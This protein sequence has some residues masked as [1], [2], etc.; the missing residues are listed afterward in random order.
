MPVTAIILVGLLLGIPSFILSLWQLYIMFHNFL[1]PIHRRPSVVVMLYHAARVVYE[2]T[3]R[4][5]VDI[6][7]DEMKI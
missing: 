7:I 1:H 3:T 5:I 6:I 4:D 2:D